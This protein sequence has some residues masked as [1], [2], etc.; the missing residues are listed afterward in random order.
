MARAR[1]LSSF[2]VTLA[3]LAV[4]VGLS[5]RREVPAR[6][7]SPAAPVTTLVNYHPVNTLVN[8]ESVTVYVVNVG[9]DSGAPAEHFSILFAD[10]KGNL[11]Q[12]EVTCDVTAGQTC[13][14]TFTCTPDTAKKATSKK[15]QVRATV[16][17]EAMG[18]VTPGMGTGD[19]T[20]NLEVFSPSG[21]SKLIYGAYGAV[22]HLP[23]ESCGPG[24]VDGGVDQSSLDGA[25]EPPDSTLPSLDSLSPPSPD[26]HAAPPVH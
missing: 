20:T 21:V 3:V 11:L 19:W 22:L 6:A 4:I 8:D 2:V 1:V 18:C 17:G 26:A 16:V 7:Q 9:T 14:A 25:P 5:L 12:S 24:G 23:T 13:S 10:N 15:C